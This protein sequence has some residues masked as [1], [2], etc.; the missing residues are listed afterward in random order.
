MSLSADSAAE[1]GDARGFGA[2]WDAGTGRTTSG[3]LPA[4]SKYEGSPL[5]LVQLGTCHPDDLTPDCA[6][7]E[8][9][10]F[11][12]AGGLTPTYDAGSADAGGDAKSAADAGA[13]PTPDAGPPP[14]LYGTGFA[15]RIEKTNA[16]P[17][18]VCRSAGPGK[19]GAECRASDDC[20]AGFE[21]VGTP[22]QCRRYCC[23][24]SASCGADRVCDKQLLVDDN[25]WVPV[26]IPVRPCKLLSPKACPDN[27]SCSVVDQADGRTGC[28]ALGS[29]TTG[30]SCEL[31][32]CVS[33]HACL[34]ST[35]A[36]TCFKL[37]S[38]SNPND[39]APGSKCQGAKPLFVDTNQGV[40]LPEIATANGAAAQQR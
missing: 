18:P 8:Q 38:K 16:S 37:C 14:D 30:E 6:K 39:C 22:G 40:C 20:S 17:A 9:P 24:G 12:D 25:L 7:A 35:N 26:C 13:A 27:E 19:D 4:A 11:A 1:V 29:A 3:A 36:R 21:C 2:S 10:N 31:S 28:V 5:C 15:C 23:L 33:G 32:N 34:G